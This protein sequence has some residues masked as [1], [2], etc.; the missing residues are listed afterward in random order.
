[1]ESDRICGIRIF[2]SPS[3]NNPQRSLT[4]IG[5]YM[6]SAENTQEVYSSYLESAEHLVSQVETDGPQLIVGDL[7]AHLGSTT[8]DRGI[9]HTNHRGTLW[10]NFISEHNLCNISLG[11]LSSGAAYTY[12][13][14]EITSTI[15]YVLTN[16]DALRGISSCVTLEDHPLNSSD[17]LPI[18]CKIDLPHLRFP[19]PPAF[20]SQSLNWAAGKKEL[21]TLKYAF[22]IARPLLNNDYTTI[23]EIE[24]DLQC[25]C[26]NLIQSAEALIPKRR[27]KKSK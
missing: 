2:L 12:S 8:I 27:F 7:N 5:I 3:S 20:P 14:G 19:P 24:C 15:D 26:K 6:P 4:I 23:D 1:M 13:S 21:H 25:V 16:Q 10:N 9:N 17:H 11:S 22:A 18:R